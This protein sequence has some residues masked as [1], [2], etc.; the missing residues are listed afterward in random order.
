MG[1]WIPLMDYAMKKGVSLSTL[2]RHIKANK[3]QYRVENGR[4]LLFVEQGDE[5]LTSRPAAASTT[6][7]VTAM[8]QPQAAPVSVPASV[9]VSAQSDDYLMAQL[10]TKLKKAQEEIAELKTL[11]AF[12]EE[13]LGFAKSNPA[14]TQPF[15]NRF[16]G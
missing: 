4:Y 2:R 16:D 8:V 3:V 5:I 10:Q 1:E 6:A 11:I 14:A 15:P 9:K 13:S 7:P 12:Y